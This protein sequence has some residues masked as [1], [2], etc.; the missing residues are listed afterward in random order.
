GISEAEHE[1]ALE[2]RVRVAPYSRRV[3]ATDRDLARLQHK[4]TGEFVA[5]WAR[6]FAAY[7]AGR[8][9]EARPLLKAALRLSNDEDGPA[10]FLL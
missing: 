7:A 10:N 6:A 5:A 1:A 9:A 3:W 2:P 8:W 4:R